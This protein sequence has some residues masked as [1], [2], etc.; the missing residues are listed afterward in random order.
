MKLQEIY[1]L[2]VR[3][4]MKAD[5]RGNGAAG[6]AL[7]KNKKAYE[8]LDKKE[9]DF[10][11]TESLTNPYADTRILFGEGDSEVKK[12]MAGIDMEGGEL[13]VA[14][15]LGDIDAVIAHHPRGRALIGLEDV[16]H[17]QADVLNQYGMPI[18]VAEGLLHKR[19]SEVSRSLSPGNHY[20]APRLAELLNMPYMCTHTVTDNLVFQFLK[21]LIEKEKPETIE[22]VLDMLFEIPEYTIARR[23]GVGPRIFA[24]APANRTGVI[25]VTEITGGTEG[26]HDI[27]EK[28][29]VAGVGT[30]IAMHQSEKHRKF[31]EEAHI[32]VVVAGH[33]SSDSIGM[34]LFL[35]EVEKG[36]VE[37]VP[38]SGLMRVSR[39]KKK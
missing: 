7:A 30:V 23:N 1:N 33:M 12:V 22:E 15:H 10:F 20:R 37:I 34:N 21:K 18:N 4:G 29:A 5:P 35:D 11:D 38:A 24:G 39:N 27:Y 8:K 31:A 28:M 26:A 25:A 16:M 13:L 9:Q 14:K 36:G 17:M 3:L 2:A 32:N 19:I 6:K